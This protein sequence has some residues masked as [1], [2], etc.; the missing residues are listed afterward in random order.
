MK[1][2]DPL[3]PHN[4]EKTIEVFAAGLLRQPAFHHKYERKTK[5][6]LGLTDTER[7]IIADGENPPEGAVITKSYE[8]GEVVERM[9]GKN[10]VHTH[11][12]HLT[13]VYSGGIPVTPIRSVK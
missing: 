8:V 2:N 12:I 3:D 10:W 7:G 4:V 11:T 6:R 5:G 13:T 1:E 9:D